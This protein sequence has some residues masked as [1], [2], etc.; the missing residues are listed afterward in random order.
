MHYFSIAK[1]D[2]LL[3]NNNKKQKYF[4]NYNLAQVPEFKSIDYITKI[5]ITIEEPIYG[6][7]GFLKFLITHIIHRNCKIFFI[8]I[9]SFLIIFIESF[10]LIP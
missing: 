6:S 5:E 7:L 3:N 10:L 9:S 1:I 4:D 2:S 8:S